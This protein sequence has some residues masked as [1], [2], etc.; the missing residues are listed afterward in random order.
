[1]LIQISNQT[2]LLMQIYKED[3]G[4]DGTDGTDD[5]VK[6]VIGEDPSTI[7]NLLLIN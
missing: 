7:Q 5:L 4:T 6:W 3:D 2:Q 1:M